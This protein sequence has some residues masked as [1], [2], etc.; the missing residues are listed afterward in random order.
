MY[1]YGFTELNLSLIQAGQDIKHAH[2]VNTTARKH[3]QSG[4]QVGMGLKEGW[5]K[6]KGKR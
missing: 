5:I 4:S 2:Y 6:L 1:V 3:T